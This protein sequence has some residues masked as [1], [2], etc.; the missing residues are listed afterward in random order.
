MSQSCTQLHGPGESNNT[1]LL[2]HLCGSWRFSSTSELICPGHGVGFMVALL[3][4]HGWQHNENHLL[5]L[6]TLYFNSC[7]SCLSKKLQGTCAHGMIRHFLPFWKRKERKL[8]YFARNNSSGSKVCC[9][10]L[11]RAYGSSPHE[12]FFLILAHKSCEHF[13]STL[14]GSQGFTVPCRN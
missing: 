10:R 3:L 6:W 8:Q 13:T 11:S 9:K 7:P 1:E 5:G 2:N 4:P 12:L 14:I